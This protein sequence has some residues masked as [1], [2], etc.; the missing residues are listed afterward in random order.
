MN[1]KEVK[2]EVSKGYELDKENS[3]FEC[4]KFKKKYLNFFKIQ[5]SH[6]TETMTIIVPYNNN[7]TEKLNAIN[8][9][10]FVAKYFNDDLVPDFSSKDDSYKYVFYIHKNQ[11]QIECIS[12]LCSHIVYFASK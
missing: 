7:Y 1:I 3:T 9:L 6:D 10:M 5:D 12:T 4:I 2:I 11:V 8:K